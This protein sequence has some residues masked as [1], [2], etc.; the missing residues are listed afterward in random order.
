MEKLLRVADMRDL[1]KKV[2]KGEISYSRMIEIINEKHFLKLVELRQE[3]RP[4]I[5]E[6]IEMWE[7][8]KNEAYTNKLMGKTP[9]SR[10]YADGKHTILEWVVRELKRKS[11]GAK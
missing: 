2:T 5:K 6:S 8:E 7:R 11:V 4:N 10:A 1:E 3:L 9:L